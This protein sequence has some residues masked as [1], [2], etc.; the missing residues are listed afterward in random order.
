MN[1]LHDEILEVI[2][3]WPSAT[4]R[5]IAEQVGVSSSSSVQWHLRVLQERGLIWRGRCEC[6]NSE[7]WMVKHSG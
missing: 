6:C 7:I 3:Q 1:A 2:E 4:V 5:F